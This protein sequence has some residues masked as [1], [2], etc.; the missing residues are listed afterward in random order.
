[1][2]KAICV[3]VLGFGLLGCSSDSDDP[4]GAGGAAGTGGGSSLP[5]PVIPQPDGACPEFVSGPQEIMGLQ[6]RILAG[7]PGSTKGPLLFTFHGTGGNADGALRQLPQS[8]QEDIVAQGG[9]VIAPSDNGQVRE[10]QDV[11]LI[12]G[13]WYDVADFRYTDHIV[14][15][16]VQNHNIDPRRIYVT[17]CSAGGLMA[18]VMSL[19]RSSYVAAAA[20]NSGG[21]VGA[22]EL[23]DPN[24]VPAVMTMHGGS[25]DTVVVNFGNTSKDLANILLPA[26]GFV[27]ECNHGLGHCRAPVE[28]HERA[29]DFMKAHPF[30]TQPSPYEPGLPAEFPSYCAIQ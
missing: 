5:T 14:A 18:G 3:A 2:N 26:G 16:A 10:G 1:M 30:G 13:V 29:W 24:H 27:V 6:T 19:A 25:A 17:G 20:P 21:V 15:C 28:L 23:E 11:T 12:L 8:V 7:S 22:R 4:K 9:I